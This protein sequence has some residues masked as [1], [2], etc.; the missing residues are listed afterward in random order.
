MTNK[1][2]EMFIINYIQTIKFMTKR[3]YYFIIRETKLYILIIPYY[4]VTSTFS[5][6]SVS[7]LS[8]NIE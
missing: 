2:R 7:Y 5:K 8:L 3:Y 1:S 4:F 6:Y